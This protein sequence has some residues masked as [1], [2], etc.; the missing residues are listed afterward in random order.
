MLK[1]YHGSCQ[2]GAIAFEADL[3]LATGT[4]RCN[5]TFCRK[6][7]NWVIRTTP[8]H[9]RLTKGTKDVAEFFPAPGQPNAHCFCSHCGVRLFSKGDIPELGGPFV[10]VAIPALDNATADELIAA[11]VFWSDGL[12]NNWWNPAAETRHL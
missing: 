11:P 10:A 1:T 8:D 2:C 6:I 4:S 5:C 7:R 3:D 12:H 9:F